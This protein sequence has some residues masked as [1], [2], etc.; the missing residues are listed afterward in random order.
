MHDGFVKARASSFTMPFAP[1]FQE[2]SV[3]RLEGIAENLLYCIA[4][5]RNQTL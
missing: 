4:F 3:S 1:I 5:L 2:E